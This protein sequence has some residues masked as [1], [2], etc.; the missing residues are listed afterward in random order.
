MERVAVCCD[1][2]KARTLWARENAALRSSLE[3]LVEVGC[4]GSVAD[5]AEAVVCL[6]VFLEGLTAIKNAQR[7]AEARSKPHVSPEG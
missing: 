2:W 1:R 4:E 3:C 6:D 5:T 7:S